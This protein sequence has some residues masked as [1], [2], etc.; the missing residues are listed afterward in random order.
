[1]SRRGL[2]ASTLAAVDTAPN[3]DFWYRP[4]STLA[5]SGLPVSAEHAMR[6]SA[7]FAC[8]KVLAEDV[9]KVPLLLYRRDGDR[10]SRATDHPLYRVL[11]DAP[12]RWQTSFGWRETMLAHLAWRGN[13]Y[14]QKLAGPDGVV[15]E[16]LPLNP[17]RVC[18]KL[19][20]RGR[21]T[22]E[23]RQ[24]AGATVQFAEEDVFHV[25][26]LSLDA[27]CGVSIIDYA[28]ETIG[29]GLAAEAYGAR[30]FANDATPGIVLSHTGNLSKPAQDRLRD[31]WVER[32]AGAHNARRPVVLEEGMTATPVSMT[33]KDSQFLETREFQVPEVCR[34]F[35]MAPHKIAHLVGSTFAS[36][37]QQNIAHVGDTLQPWYTRIEQAISAQLL[38]DEEDVYA[39]FEVKG[40]LRGDS[41]A[42]AAY[43]TARFG[44]GTMSRNDIRRAENEEPLPGGDDTYVPLNMARLGPDGDLIDVTTPG[45]SDAGA[46]TDSAP[47]GGVPTPPSAKPDRFRGAAVTVFAPLVA[48]AAARIHGH[49]VA[50]LSKPSTFAVSHRAQ[51]DAAIADCFAPDGA[52]ARF[53]AKALAPIGAAW[54]LATG[55]TLDAAA[56]AARVLEAG[57]V[58][59]GADASALG[60]GRDATIRTLIWEAF[61]HDM[62]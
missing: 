11:H 62:E 17:D 12:N 31:S 15:R 27:I 7:A 18:V 55:D 22:F 51:W 5:Q 38:G 43:F 39:E 54:R 56:L 29:I 13:Y 35:R 1:M 20:D 9:A 6:L 32:H 33:S 34:W 10:R 21:K 23:Y 59:I 16:L 61:G 57:H 42:R 40:L 37:E 8:V 28:R 36:L 4:V 45:S 44:I 52:H 14:A 19:D 60:E 53:A 2:L 49:E 3:A 48:D 30:T 24:P 46:A 41:A 25:V 50:K 58:A 47:P 26:G